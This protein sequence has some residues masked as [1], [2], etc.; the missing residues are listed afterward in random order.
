MIGDE[1][2]VVGRQVARAEQRGASGR[3][4]GRGARE[5]EELGAHEQQVEA[6]AECVARGRT[7]QREE[8]RRHHQT[9]REQPVLPAR[10]RRDAIAPRTRTRASA[11]RQSSTNKSIRCN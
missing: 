9:R 2:A 5:R 6:G 1:E 4:D 10:P 3:P 7:Q 11:Q 8:E